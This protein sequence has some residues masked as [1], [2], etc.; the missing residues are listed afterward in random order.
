MGGRWPSLRAGVSASDPVAGALA[1]AGCE[2]T[3]PGLGPVFFVGA[4]KFGLRREW[5]LAPGYE[6]DA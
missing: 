2:V 3:E 6:P 4:S 5:H 1:G